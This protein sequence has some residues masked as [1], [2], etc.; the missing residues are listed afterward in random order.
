MKNVMSKVFL[1]I[2]QLII[3]LGEM[4]Q[5][6]RGLK[7]FNEID[8]QTNSTLMRALKDQ[9]LN[10][11]FISGL[12]LIRL[13]NDRSGNKKFALINVWNPNPI[14]FSK[15]GNGKMIILPTL[16]NPNAVVTAVLNLSGNHDA[17]V[18]LM[19]LMRT[20]CTSN[21]YVT[22]ASGTLTELD[23]LILAYQD[24]HGPA[25]AVT[26]VPLKAA[27]NAIM[28]TFQL[29]ANQPVNKSNSIVILQS[30]GWH[31]MGVGG[32]HPQIWEALQS[33]ITGEIL[34]TFVAYDKPHC[35]DF[36]SSTDGITWLRMEP[37]IHAHARIDGLTPNTFVWV[38]YQLVTE[39]GGQGYSTPIK[40]QVPA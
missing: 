21:I 38:R 7:A 16:P 28:L 24:A 36:C 33:N 20:K 25:R 23:A 6:K 14:T 3:I 26:L 30:G 17:D 40:I 5:T 37:V 35:Y 22:T 10:S 32:S 39:A 15:N 11:K 9:F 29:F 8:E 12:K 18:T 27:L 34:M 13:A 31:V 4:V 1:V 19:K 2:I